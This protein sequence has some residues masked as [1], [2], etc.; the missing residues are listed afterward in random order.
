MTTKKMLPSDLEF[1]VSVHLQSFP[2]FFLSF[3]GT[4]FLR[5]LY[6][7]ILDD[8]SGIAYVY[9]RN[10]KISGFIVGTTLPSGFYTRLLRYRWLQFAWA[11]LL[12]AIK[13]PS[14][15]PRL[16]RAFQR[17]KAEDVH[18]NCATLMSIAVLPEVHGQGIGQKLIQAFLVE[19]AKRGIRRV[20]LTTDAV[21][22]D[23]VN[24]F[25]LK[26]GFKLFKSFTTPEGRLMNEYVIEL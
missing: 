4:S 14:I 7:A 25:Y 12:P 15:I 23:A 20:N 19:A 26:Q 11:S 1:V 13:N 9:K 17:G 16:L 21:T 5:E 18:E 6:G 22:N 24:K 8:V 3:L 10:E 2:N